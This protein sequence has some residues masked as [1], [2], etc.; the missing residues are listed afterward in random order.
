MRTKLTIT[1][2]IAL[3]L[4]VAFLLIVQVPRAYDQAHYQFTNP[5]GG[6]SMW[7]ATFDGFFSI[8]SVLICIAA[9]SFLFGGVLGATRRCAAGLL[10]LGILAA[11]IVSG[12]LWQSYGFSQDSVLG[13]MIRQE[14]SPINAIGISVLSLAAVVGKGPFTTLYD[15]F[16]K[17][18]GRNHRHA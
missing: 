18:R 14:V 3:L 4:F 5:R 13:Y 2:N 7:P 11:W 12:S 10:A 15:L 16:C 6:P 17:F 8:S 1:W 9:F